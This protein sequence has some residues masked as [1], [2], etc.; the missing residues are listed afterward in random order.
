MRLCYSFFIFDFIFSE[1]KVT[2]NENVSFADHV[3]GIRNW[4]KI[5]KIIMTSQFTSMIPLS[6]IFEAA[7]FLLL[8]L[9]T[10]SRF[11]SI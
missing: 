11:M 1:I 2:F 6:N 9:V 4:Q 3:S 8:S 5:G 10:G 7:V